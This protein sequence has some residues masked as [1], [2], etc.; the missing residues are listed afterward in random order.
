M[1]NERQNAINR[2]REANERNRQNDWFFDNWEG[3]F[4]KNVKRAARGLG[5]VWALSLIA[6]LA[7]WGV[8]IWAIIELVQHFT[9]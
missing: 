1:R 4:D 7:F 6:S 9:A 2:L 8:V 5:V 3:D